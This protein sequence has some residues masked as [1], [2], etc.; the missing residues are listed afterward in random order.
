[1]D[2]L[3]ENPLARM[4]G[5]FFLVLYILL[6]VAGFIYILF[7]A[8]KKAGRLRDESVPV[9]PSQPNVYEIAYLRGGET[10]VMVLVIYSLI[11]RDYFTLCTDKATSSIALRKAKNHANVNALSMMEKQVCNLLTGDTVVTTFSKYL[12]KDPDFLKHC[13][14]IRKKLESEKTIWGDEERRKF[15]LLKFC[16]IGGLISL[17]LYKLLAA[18]A[19]GHRN[20]GFLFFIALLGSVILANIKSNTVPTSKGYK[21]LEQFK[22]IFKPVEGNNLLKQPIYLQ[23][24]LLALYGFHLLSSTSYFNFHGHVMVKIP[25]KKSVSYDSGSSSGSCSSASGCGSSCGGGCGG[26]CGGCS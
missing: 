9:I 12:I 1:M 6:Y 10:E 2:S 17:G 16:V 4:Y 23:Q 3:Y 24:L 11:K 18:T 15:I 21:I 26:G 20:V 5:P 19:H 7:F 25:E 14:S 22:N 8:P 13:E